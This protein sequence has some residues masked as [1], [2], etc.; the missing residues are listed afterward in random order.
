MLLINSLNSLVINAVSL[1][2]AEYPELSPN[3]TF[4]ISYLKSQFKYFFWN[5]WKNICI[6]MVQCKTAVIPLLIHWSY[7][8]HVLSHRYAVWNVSVNIFSISWERNSACEEMTKL[9]SQ[10]VNWWSR[11]LSKTTMSWLKSV[12]LIS[13][14]NTATETHTPFDFFFLAKTRILSLY[15]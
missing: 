8:S 1:H 12:A 3:C 10:L 4:Q 11:G 6:S 13:W 7:C 9:A 14:L 15:I 2:S 5:S